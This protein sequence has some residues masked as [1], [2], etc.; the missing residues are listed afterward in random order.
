MAGEWFQRRLARLSN[1]WGK[2]IHDRPT[3]NSPNLLPV[4]PDEID[5]SG[6]FQDF[7]LKIAHISDLH[8]GREHTEKLAHVKKR[9]EEISPHIVVITGDTVD[10]PKSA[11]FRSAKTFL[12]YLSNKGWT[13][14]L[15]P[16]NHDRHGE[17]DLE[18]WKEA[19]ERQKSYDCKFLKLKH[20]QYLT[21][22]LLDSTGGQYESKIETT[23]ANVLQV[24]GRIDDDQL[25]WMTNIHKWLLDNRR[26]EFLNSFKVVA[27]HHHPL[28]TSVKTNYKDLVLSLENAGEVLDLFTKIQ[29]DLVLHGH[30]HDPMIQVLSRGDAQREMAILGAGTALR[31]TGDEQAYSISKDSSFYLI[32]VAAKKY[33][34][35]QY[36]Y[37]NNIPM[38]N[39]FCPVRIVERR[40][41][42]V[43]VIPRELE[44]TWVISFPSTDFRYQEVHTFHN[45][46]YGEPLTE[47]IF[48]AG[49]TLKE[50]QAL[51][52]F[53]TLSV[54]AKRMKDGH[55]VPLELS[56]P[57]PGQYFDWTRRPYPYYKMKAL[58]QP[59]ISKGP[60]DN[61]LSFEI[62][63]PQGFWELGETSYFEETFQFPYPLS[64]FTLNVEF[65]GSQSITRL[66]VLP[67]GETTGE[68]V[69]AWYEDKWVH[70][71][72]S[73]SALS[74][75]WKY[76]KYDIS[77]M[78]SIYFAITRGG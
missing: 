25:H 46:D 59:P 7:P 31:T 73:G 5:L 22:F 41:T 2:G 64:K 34:V 24:K 13:F 49:L 29:V 40:R 72:D 26:V 15:L 74:K 43:E 20:G 21:L 58:L 32:E 61:V 38:S 33:V 3:A 51:P 6:T 78:R 12:Q 65:I 56:E 57:E 54:M 66:L 30:Q 16:G 55:D 4:Q 44:L 60:G 42:S 8:F 1:W 45:P 67:L 47:H 14:F 63:V 77:S 75:K 9:L 76:V 18:K 71:S 28:P 19:F 52:A 17:I 10:E 39:K 37:A 53:D 69:F 62:L 23:L 68:G 36:C 27:L 70:V 35:S 11:N 50:G 48:I